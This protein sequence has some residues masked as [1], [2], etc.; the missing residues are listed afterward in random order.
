[1][2]NGLNKTT[3]LMGKTY[4]GIPYGLAFDLWKLEQDGKPEKAVSL[5]NAMNS[6]RTAFG[7]KPHDL[8]ACFSTLPMEGGFTIVEKAA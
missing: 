5:L 3:T 6:I 4:E 7:G 1:M 8:A 2:A